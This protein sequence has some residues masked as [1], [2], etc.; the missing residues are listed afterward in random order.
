MC[1]R[2]S[3]YRGSR[4]SQ[5]N[6]YYIFGD[7]INSKVWALKYDD[8]NVSNFQV[9]ANPA[10]I[11]A[12]GAEPSN[13]DVLAANIANGTIQRLIY[14][15]NTVTGTPL[16]PT[17]AVTGAFTNLTTLAANPGIVPYD[18]NV[19]FWSDN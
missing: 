1:I 3:I 16:P 4:I 2:D 9:L 19:P 6:G 12:F 13:G 5:L 15:T 10:S 14:N 11:V 7:Y 17:L 18:I 8:T